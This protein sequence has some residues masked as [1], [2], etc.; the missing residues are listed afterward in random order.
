MKQ[1]TLRILTRRPVGPPIQVV[2]SL[3]FLFSLTVVIQ[4]AAQPARVGDRD[5]PIWIAAS[6]VLYRDGSFRDSWSLSGEIR[7]QVRKQS[8]AFAVAYPLGVQA[9][10]ELEDG[11]RPPRE[12][13]AGV[14]PLD[15]DSPRARAKLFADERFYDFDLTVLTSKVAVVATVSDL[16]PGFLANGDPGLL[17][18]LSEVVPLHVRS[19]LPSYTLIP[20]DQVMIRGRAFC[21]DELRA[22]YSYERP[23]VG[24]RVVLIGSLWARENV[25]RAWFY[26]EGRFA[27]ARGEKHN[28]PAL[29]WATGYEPYVAGVS[30]SRLSRTSRTRRCRVCTT[31]STTCRRAGCSS[32]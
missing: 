21:A 9:E 25:V 20:T 8:E 16:I 13:C 7:E 10:E 6:G 29:D 31:T 11:A 30:I 2:V 22:E 4:A 24:D 19:E 26:Y 14:P 17:L 12:L 1:W 18:E 15:P 3:V 32:G 5:A 27:V 28:E 23:E